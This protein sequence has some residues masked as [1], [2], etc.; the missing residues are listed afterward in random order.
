MF[1][2]LR[3]TRHIQMMFANIVEFKCPHSRDKIKRILINNEKS[4]AS[5]VAGVNNN[6]FVITKQFIYYH[7]RRLIKRYFVRSLMDTTS[8][9][10]ELSLRKADYT[11]MIPI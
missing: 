8:M 3:R 5:N 2:G 6:N 1:S 7:P 10:T 9:F 4:L 11:F